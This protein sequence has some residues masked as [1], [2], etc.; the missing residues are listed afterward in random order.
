MNTRSVCIVLAFL[1]TALFVAAQETA[2]RN[3]LPPA[4][5]IT[6]SGT[7]HFI[8]AF[9]GPTTIRDST[10]FET[11]GLDVGIGT[12]SP[13]AT[14]DVNGTVNAEGSFNLGGLAFAFGSHSN[15][16]AFFGFA[17]NFTMTGTANTA[18]GAG[19]LASNTT[20]TYNIAIGEN[21]LVFNTTGGANTAIGFQ[22]LFSNT[23][24]SYNTADGQ[25]TLSSNTTGILN[26]AV[27]QAALFSN[28]TGTANNASGTGALG[29]NTTGLNN[30][31]CEN[32]ASPPTPPAPA[33]LLWATSRGQTR[34]LTTLAIP[35]P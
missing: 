5:T 30:T 19:A 20:G 18:V 32:G 17:G 33:T 29:S 4:G 8:P 1:S 24:G 22:A 35:L 3:S 27:G 34:A 23:T 10:I 26:T 11:S 9:S 16:N 7:A 12:T 28:T 2:S 31:A 13:Q 15:A 21:A 14:L 6:G 25:A